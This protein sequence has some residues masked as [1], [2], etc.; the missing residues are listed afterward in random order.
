MQICIKYSSSYVPYVWSRLLPV[1]S[2]GPSGE[3]ISISTMKS[4]I[5]SV[6]VPYDK[7]LTGT[8]ARHPRRQ[9]N[10]WQSMLPTLLIRK[11]IRSVHWQLGMMTKFIWWM[12]ICRVMTQITIFSDTNN[13]SQLEPQEDDENTRDISVS[14]TLQSWHDDSSTEHDTKYDGRQLCTIKN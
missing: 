2:Y 12:M 10:C 4:Y 13:H 3:M 1:S 7:H 11:N 8:H 5:K 14:L 9:L 6:T